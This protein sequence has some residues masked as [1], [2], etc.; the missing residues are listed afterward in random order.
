MPMEHSPA[1]NS[2]RYRVGP[3]SIEN[4]NASQEQTPASSIERAPLHWWR[5]RK[6]QDFDDRHVKAI[7][8]ALLRTEIIDDSDWLR[9]VTGEPA[10][11][12]GVALKA[13]KV[14]GMNDP[15]IDAVVSAVL[16]CALEGDPAARVLILSALSRRKKIDPRCHKLKLLWRRARF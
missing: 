15:M 7:R 8:T 14:L 5:T 1:Q 10:T 16:C 11:A 6:P 12:I 4:E 2:V 3:S 9:A 13:L